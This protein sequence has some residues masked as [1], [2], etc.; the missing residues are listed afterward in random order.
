MTR[1][2]R[3]CACAHA[4]RQVDTRWVLISLSALRWGTDLSVTRTH[5]HTKAYILFCSAVIREARNMACIISG[6]AMLSGAPCLCVP[7]ALDPSTKLKVMSCQTTE[8]AW[9]LKAR[10][11]MRWPIL[12]TPT[13]THTHTHTA[14]PTRA[15]L[16]DFNMTGLLERLA[17]ERYLWLFSQACFLQVNSWKS[18]C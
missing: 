1:R 18:A 10:T 17:A 14:R 13:V 4:D 6:P 7:L 3:A 2:V 5:M 11:L 8:K 15:G 16:S 12:H 9:L